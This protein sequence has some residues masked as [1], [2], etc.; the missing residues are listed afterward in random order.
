MALSAGEAFALLQKAWQNERLAHAC[1]ITGP[2]GSGKRELAAQL[3][4]LIIGESTG[5]PLAHPDVHTVQPESKS[6]RI[7]VEQMRT[8]EGELRM[9]ALSGGPKVGIIFDAER[10]QPQAANAFLKTLEEP[11]GQSHL[12]LV[13]ALPDQLLETIISRCM[14]VALRAPEHR[15]RTPRQTELLTLLARSH[16]RDAMDLPGVYGLVRDFQKLLS[17][18]KETSQEQ[19]ERDWKDEEKRYKQTAD[20]RWLEDREEQFKAIAEARYV[21]ERSLLIE[22][23]ELWW[24][25]ILRQQAGAERLDFADH[26][27]AISAVAARL[28]PAAALQRSAAIERLREQLNNPGLQEQL[29][30]EVAFAGAFGQS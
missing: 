25:D 27:P 29:A 20:P 1:L 6:R 26:A 23:L 9:R 2:V 11:P 13:S 4:G 30:I 18:S 17:E 3:S 8:L 16:S 19:A 5:D 24:A 15:E 7:V 21:A 22:T 12:I 28:S 14:E 10:L